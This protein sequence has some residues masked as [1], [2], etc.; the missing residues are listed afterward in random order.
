MSKLSASQRN[1]LPSD[2]FAGPDDSYPVNDANHARAAL[3]GS[4]RAFNAHK[5][6]KSL[7]QRIQAKARA[8]LKGNRG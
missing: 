7:K 3:S 1:K 8:V 2:E 6:S 4:S 5:I